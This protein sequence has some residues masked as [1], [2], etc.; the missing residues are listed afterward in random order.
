MSDFP[1]IDPRE[2]D[3]LAK[4]YPTI[5]RSRI[6]LVLDAYWPVKTDVEAALLETVARQ[7][8]EGDDSLDYTPPAAPT[9]A[10]KALPGRL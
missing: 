9:L 8:R 7:Q 4:R 10:E 3:D 5:G 6:E 1:W 2:V